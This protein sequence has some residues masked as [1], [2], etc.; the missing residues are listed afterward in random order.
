MSPRSSH[1]SFLKCLLV[2]DNNLE[3]VRES[4]DKKE[5]RE[6]NK[7]DIRKSLVN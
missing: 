2:S 6:K 3:E 4:I 7:E 1:Q 5:A